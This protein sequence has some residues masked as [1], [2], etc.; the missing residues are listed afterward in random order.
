ML[1][2]HQFEIARHQMEIW[3]IRCSDNL[4]DRAL[5]FVIPDCSVERFVGPDIELG[6]VSEQRGEACLRV[7]VDS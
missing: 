3:D 4:G 2:L 6:L 1:E 7:Q 5:L